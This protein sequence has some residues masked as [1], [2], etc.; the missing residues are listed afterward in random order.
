MGVGQGAAALSDCSA[1]RE[2]EKPDGSVLCGGFRHRRKARK[3][4]FAKAC[5]QASVSEWQT[6]KTQNLLRATACG[7]ESHR[8]QIK[9]GRKSQ[10]IREI[11]PLFLRFP[12]LGLK[13]RFLALQMIRVSERM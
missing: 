11:L 5:R 8:W 2:P 1:L 7:F 4:L 13:N 10:K 6:R 9:N 3:D 12:N